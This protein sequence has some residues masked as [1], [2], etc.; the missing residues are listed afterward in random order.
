MLIE[1]LFFFMF[2][3]QFLVFAIVTMLVTGIFAEAAGMYRRPNGWHTGMM[4]AIAFVLGALAVF[5]TM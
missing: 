2:T 5:A 3:W 4:A 1:R